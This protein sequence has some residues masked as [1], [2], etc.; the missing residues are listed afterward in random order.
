MPDALSAALITWISASEG[1]AFRGAAAG[2]RTTAG[3]AAGIAAR[4]AA[5]LLERDSD[6][7]RRMSDM[8]TGA[9][10]PFPQGLPAASRPVPTR[11]T[12]VKAASQWTDEH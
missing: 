3:T 9:A 5:L 8:D 1:T 2:A 6:S 7:A 4:A 12:S 11:K 10:C